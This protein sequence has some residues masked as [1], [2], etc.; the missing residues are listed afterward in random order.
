[1]QAITTTILKNT[2]THAKKLR[3]GAFAAG[4]AW[5]SDTRTNQMKQKMLFVNINF[6]A[7]FCRHQGCR[8][9]SLEFVLRFE[10][11][12]LMTDSGQEN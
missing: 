11:A 8:L 3:I 6:E 1:M 4:R 12:L 7:E 2:D 5:A 9:E 10:N